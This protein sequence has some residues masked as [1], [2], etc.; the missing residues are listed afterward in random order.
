M[1]VGVATFLSGVLSGITGAAIGAF[2]AFLSY[3]MAQKQMDRQAM[4]NERNRDHESRQ[5]AMPKRLEAI[6]R[7][8][9]TLFKMENAIDMTQ[10]DH[11]DFIGAQMW[12]PDDL[13]TS[14]LSLYKQWLARR[15]APETKTLLSACRKG[16]IAM[17]GLD[18]R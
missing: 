14:C 18:P 13:R 1:D 6:E 3:K 16:I 4:E 5:L 10:A 17:T 2:S 8:W 12:L 15:N 7:I 11:D 9:R